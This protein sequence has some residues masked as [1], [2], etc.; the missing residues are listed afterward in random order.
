MYTIK[1]L[2]RKNSRKYTPKVSFE[3]ID[4]VK[5]YL[6]DNEIM[7]AGNDPYIFTYLNLNNGDIITNSYNGIMCSPLELR[8]A[9][10]A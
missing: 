1:T 2:K 4:E 9:L 5:K 10:K 7:Y 3:A 6:N 8:E